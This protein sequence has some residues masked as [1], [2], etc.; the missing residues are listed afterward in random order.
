M[1][2]SRSIARECL[3]PGTTVGPGEV[4][5]ATEIGDPSG[6]LLPCPAAPLVGGTLRRRGIRVSYATV[7]RCGDASPSDAGATLFVTS[8]LQRNGV[9]T[10]IGAGASRVDGVALAAARAAVEEWSAVV[11]TRRLMD[12]VSP[13]CHGARQA[14]RRVR[15]ALAATGT[16]YVYGHLA[17]SPQVRAELEKE[18]AV[19]ATSLHEIPNEATVL[20]PAH[21]AAPDVLD[22]ATARALDVIDA[23][24]PLVAAAQAE[25]RRYA[26]RGD[27][28]V[29]IGQAGHPVVP[30]ILGQAPGRSIIA[31][32]PASAGAVSAADPRHVSYLPLPGIPV[33]DTTS[34]A[35]AL[36]SRFPAAR[37]PDPDT[38]CYAPSDRTETIRTVA[39]SC[40]VVLVLGTEDDADTRYLTGLARSCHAKAHVIAD[41]TEIL[42][43]WLA[44]TSA[45][46]LAESTSPI[47]RLADQV[48][49]ALS[50]LGPLSV[51][52][53]HV[54]T[55]VTSRPAVA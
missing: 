19:F 43:S 12:A 42:P 16:V 3:A 8:A 14:L 41:V 25:V 46:G 4:L 10:A 48:T 50:G 26:D 5:V 17:V 27:Q 34:V 6:R 23:T 45:I 44:G 21:G 40:D 52:R 37:S 7:P 22:Q 11:G 55:Q 13:W 15:Q 53:R 35:A 20:I 51:T 39:T 49:R 2:M 1:A 29:L 31:G 24:C 47:P 33:E 32:S 38:F 28:V 9:G 54:S 18:G 36:R 30:G